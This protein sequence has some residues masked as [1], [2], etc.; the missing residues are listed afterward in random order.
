MQ[1]HCCNGG[2]LHDVA[3]VVKSKTAVKNDLCP[4]LFFINSLFSS[5]K[6]KISLPCLNFF[7]E[8]A[9]KDG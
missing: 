4:I 8:R 5:S 7:E 1:F 9:D 3:V 2:V 6:V